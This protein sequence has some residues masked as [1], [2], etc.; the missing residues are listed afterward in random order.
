MQE[1][2][3][4]TPYELVGGPCDGD[5][6]RVPNDIEFPVVVFINPELASDRIHAWTTEY[7]CEV[8]RTRYAYKDKK[9]HHVVNLESSNG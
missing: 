7:D 5:C 2:H 1:H 9:F 6:I 4:R 8:Y 3:L